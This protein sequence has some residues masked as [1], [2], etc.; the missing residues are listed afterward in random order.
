ML[1]LKA[2]RGK[3]RRWVGAFATATVA[4]LALSIVVQQIPK[5]PDLSSGD[6][7]RLDSNVPGTLPSEAET[8][9]EQESTSE[10]MPGLRRSKSDLMETEE[11]ARDQMVRTP[12]VWIEFMLELQKTERHDELKIERDAF[13]KIYPDYLLPPELQD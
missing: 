4:V 10:A 3:R 7:I 12:E 1:K 9:V 8:A 11:P 5:T 2:S 13:R 6:G